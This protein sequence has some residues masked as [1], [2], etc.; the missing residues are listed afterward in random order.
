MLSIAPAPSRDDGNPF[1]HGRS[2]TGEQRKR[3]EDAFHPAWMLAKAADDR[4]RAA[5]HEFSALRCRASDEGKKLPCWNDI[6]EPSM[7]KMLSTLDTAML[8]P[9]GAV[10][11]LRWKQQELKSTRTC[12]EVRKID[13]SRWERAIAA[14]EARLGKGAKS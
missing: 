10:R 1:R 2:V 8:T 7:K 3:M 9:A 6:V 12:V 14:D 4:L 5:Q 13:V 11:H